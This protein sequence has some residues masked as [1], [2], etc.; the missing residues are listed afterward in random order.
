MM[1]RL[2]CTRYAKCT[3]I[4]KVCSYL[5]LPVCSSLR[6]LHLFSYYQAISHHC[7]LL[8]LKITK[9]L[10]TYNKS[11]LILEDF[12]IGNN[13]IKIGNLILNTYICDGINRVVMT[14]R[15]TY[16]PSNARIQD[17]D[18]LYF[19]I[20]CLIMISTF[21]FDFFLFGFFFVNLFK[22]CL[23]YTSPSPRDRG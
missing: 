7:Q 10:S 3:N 19:V 18:L 11:A 5:L 20:F 16:G 22:V 21:V 15:K 9:I 12:E 23:L 8:V 14:R 1:I 13:Y 6:Q 17:H 4:E 2:K